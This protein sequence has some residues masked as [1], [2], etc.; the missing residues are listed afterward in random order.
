MTYYRRTM[1][2]AYKEVVLSEKSIST[3]KNG[4]KVYGNAL[5]SRAI[6]DKMA[7][8]A[9]METGKE[10][11]TYQSPFNNRFYVRI[12][13]ELEESFSDAQ[14][15][16]LKKEYEPLRGKKISIDN[17]N[18]LGAMFTKF[19]SSKNALEKLYGGDIP[20][21]STM[22]MTRLMTKHNYTASKINALRKCWPLNVIGAPDI[23]P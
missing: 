21:I 15:A 2:E 12:K 10:C 7:H 20:F 14:I 11:D 17:A 1:T 6:A 3:L 8:K 13:E 23:I 9:E 18:K 16:K 22:A 19:D 5:P 4:V